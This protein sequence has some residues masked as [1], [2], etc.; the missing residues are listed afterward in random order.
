MKLRERDQMSALYLTNAGD[1]ALRQTLLRCKTGQIHTG[2]VS[3]YVKIAK[4]V[5]VNILNTEQRDIYV[6]MNKCVSLTSEK[7]FTE[8]HLIACVQRCTQTINN[9][10]L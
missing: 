4:K 6:N 8:V 10:E 9:I 2:F 5:K 3:N 1:K 7:F